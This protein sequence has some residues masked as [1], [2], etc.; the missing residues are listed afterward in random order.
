[1]FLDPYLSL[2]ID[3]ISLLCILLIPPSIHCGRHMSKGLSL[4]E[5]RHA[6]PRGPNFTLNL[7]FLGMQGPTQT[8]PDKRGQEFEQVAKEEES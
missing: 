4:I 5:V 1:M 6:L 2:A 3:L 8:Q 7:Q